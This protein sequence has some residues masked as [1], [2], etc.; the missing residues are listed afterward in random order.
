M[1]SHFLCDVDARKKRVGKGRAQVFSPGEEGNSHSDRGERD[2]PDALELLRGMHADSSEAWHMPR[3]L[4]WA[5]FVFP[6][7]PLQAYAREYFI[8][9]ILRIRPNTY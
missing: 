8:H 2:L 6:C 9:C 7:G 4:K 5:I 3:L 1:I